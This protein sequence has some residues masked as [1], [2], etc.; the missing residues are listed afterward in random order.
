MKKIYKMQVIIFVL[1]LLFSS[2]LPNTAFADSSEY[3][4]AYEKIKPDSSFDLN[5]DEINDVS[6][7]SYYMDL[8]IRCIGTAFLQNISLKIETDIG[9]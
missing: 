5:I 7:G 3:D 6:S 4:F 8:I 1:I 9:I 2:V